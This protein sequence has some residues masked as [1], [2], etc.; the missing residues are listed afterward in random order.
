MATGQGIRAGRAFVELFADESQL[1][2]G[3]KAAQKRLQTF[4]ASVRAIGT[5]IFA[6]GASVAAPLTGALTVF[7][8][9]GD[10]LD[11]MAART[12]VSVEAL[13]EL[14]FAAEQSGSSLESVGSA[15]FRMRR[16][17]A[18]AATASG[19]AVRAL[20]ELGLSAQDL[21][22][23]APEDQFLMLA[24]RLKQVQNE[25]LAAQYAFELFGNGAESLLP[26]LATGADGI[27][28]LRQQAKA[29]GLT[30]ST[31]DA[32]A[33]A[34]FT[35]A[36]SILT[37]TLKSGL[38]A[39]GS[40][41]APELT[42]LAERMARLV[43][44]AVDW[45]RQNRGLIVTTL[46]VA[47]AVMAGGAALIGLGTALSLAGTAL[48]GIATL[49]T[50]FGTVLGAVLSPIGLVS[51]AVLG[52]GGYL[53]YLSG[54]GGKA[55]DW[56]GEK[57][58]FLKTTALGA[59]QGISDALAAGDFSLAAK[60]L[61]LTL[62]MEWQRGVNALNQIWIGVKDTFLAVWTEAVYGVA[63]IAT[64]AWAG[65]QSGWVE[66]VDFLMDAWTLFTSGIT[67]AWHTAVGFIRKAWV[68]LKSLFDADL[69]VDA[70][71]T[72]INQD[73]AG[74]QAATATE[75]DR[76]IG[77]REQ[78]RR[79]RLKEIDAGRTG[80]LDELEQLR[81]ADHVARHKRNQADLSASEEALNRARTDWQQAIAEAARKRREVESDESPASPQR[82][83]DLTEDFQQRAASARTIDF[84][85][86]QAQQQAIQLQA[87]GAG[88]SGPE[89]QTAKNT[90]HMIAELKAQNKTLRDLLAQ[91][92]KP[93]APTRVA[94]IG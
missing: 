76:R 50:L 78:A 58:G 68:R 32:S 30:V 61:W 34:A 21:M 37:K 22:Q 8:G 51:A 18:N 39:V 83:G 2:R 5:R 43:K 19:P 93:V 82:F 11:K 62:Q 53:L 89:E 66:T 41:L 56:L 59:W 47:V 17:V 49:V 60:V 26:L 70:E 81:E 88:A 3:L 28:A 77:E 87:L 24:G 27:E 23:L 71:V 94:T 80:T 31:D 72:R 29:F 63:R 92:R 69:N 74:Q 4:G 25:S 46:K 16:R 48:G 86:T 90:Q 1:V 38:L 79:Q 84:G 57:F 7:A 75:R 54:T 13:S 6:A 9:T 10:Q 67:Q 35:D 55:L 65:L 15:L 91:Q 44:T 52:L 12:G 85:L 73:V 42:G 45:A 40:A 14:G 33:A 36:L 64:E 20:Q